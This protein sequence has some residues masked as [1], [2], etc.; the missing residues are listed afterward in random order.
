MDS[1]IDEEPDPSS[2]PSS[3]NESSG[4]SDTDGGK[5]AASRIPYLSGCSSPGLADSLLFSHLVEVATSKTDLRGLARIRAEFPTLYLYFVHLCQEFFHVKGEVEGEEQEQSASSARVLRKSNNS[6]LYQSLLASHSARTAELPPALAEFVMLV[7]G[8][9]APTP[10]SGLEC[11]TLQ[12]VILVPYVNEPSHMN[13]TQLFRN[14]Y[15]LDLS[16]FRTPPSIDYVPPRTTLAVR[17]L[18]SS[19]TSDD[20]LG[21]EKIEIDGNPPYIGIRCLVFASLVL[22]SFVKSAID[23]HSMNR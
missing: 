21:T 23:I 6:A 13:S 10:S 16:L 2:N 8:D 17:D 5:S 1:F 19:T 20:V 22:G 15:S 18:G 12:R 7:F 9:K 3:I 4:G 14:R 11:E